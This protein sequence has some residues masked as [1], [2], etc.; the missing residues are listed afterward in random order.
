M[1]LTYQAW[2]RLLIHGYLCHSTWLVLH[3]VHATEAKAV[4]QDEPSN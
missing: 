1:W 2:M 3:I 4:G